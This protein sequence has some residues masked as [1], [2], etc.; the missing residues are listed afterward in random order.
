LSGRAALIDEIERLCRAIVAEKHI[1]VDQFIVR[2][3]RVHDD[4]AA[5]VQSERLASNSPGANGVG[6]GCHRVE[7]QPVDRHTQPKVDRRNPLPGPLN[8]A[9]S[10][11]PGTIAGSVN[12]LVLLDHTPSVEPSQTSL[13]ASACRGQQR[14]R[15]KKKQRR[16][17]SGKNA[18][19]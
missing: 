19:F 15:V 1:R 16:N 18:A 17:A 5:I 8:V 2:Y 9:V 7:N 13:V 3:G 12:Q 14:E 11:M 4:P 6:G 10:P